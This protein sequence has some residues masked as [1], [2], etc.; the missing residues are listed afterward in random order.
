MK[1]TLPVTALSLLASVSIAAT[2]D[3]TYTL[4]RN[5]ITDQSMRIHVGTFDSVDGSEYNRENCAQAAFLFQGQAKVKT[6][7]WCESGRFKK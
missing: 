1:T 7:F 2:A 3:S 6:K 4:Y 5:S